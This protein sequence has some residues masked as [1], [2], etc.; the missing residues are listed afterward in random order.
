MKVFGTAALFLLLEFV[1]LTVVNAGDDL[2]IFLRGSTNAAPKEVHPGPRSVE[3]NLG[4]LGKP[5]A[6]FHLQR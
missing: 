6:Q 5:V 2:N 1:A 4:N 3:G